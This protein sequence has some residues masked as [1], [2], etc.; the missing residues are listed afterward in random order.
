MDTQSVVKTYTY[1]LYSTPE[2]ERALETILWRCR[3]LYNAA[4]EGRKTAW[5]RCGVSLNY[6]QQANE[7][8]DLKAACPEYGEVHSQVLQDV[9]KRLERTY[10]AFFRRIRDG[11]QPGRPLQEAQSLPQ[12]HLSPIRQ[13]RDAGWWDT[14]A[15]SHWPHPTQGAATS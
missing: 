14:L 12:L 11:G 8:P 1:R 13:R 6:Y 4:L 5:E 15:L 10:Q 9:L 3:A 2:Q 7:L